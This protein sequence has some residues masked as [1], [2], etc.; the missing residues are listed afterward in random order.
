MAHGSFLD[1][2]YGTHPSYMICGTIVGLAFG[3][4]SCFFYQSSLSGWILWGGVLGI[5]ISHSAGSANFAVVV[6]TAGTAVLLR[7]LRPTIRYSVVAFSTLF[8]GTAVISNFD[9]DRKY[10]YLLSSSRSGVLALVVALVVGRT[11]AYAASIN[12]RSEE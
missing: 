5:L 4:A 6:F 7:E 2:I 1:T 10:F 8:A 11:M 3:F 9:T 12:N